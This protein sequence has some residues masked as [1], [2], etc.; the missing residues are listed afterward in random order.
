MHHYSADERIRSARDTT[1]LSVLKVTTRSNEAQEKP[2][3]LVERNFTAIRRD[4]LW[5][6]DM[7][8]V[9]IGSK[10]FY[11]AFVIDVYS[12]KIAG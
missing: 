12:R 2:R 3:D 9:Q 7:T 4:A 5:V 6:A 11:L 10:F 8:Y 1:R